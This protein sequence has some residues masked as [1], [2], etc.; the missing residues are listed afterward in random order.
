MTDNFSDS[1][2]RVIPLDVPQVET[3][4]FDGLLAEVDEL[5]ASRER[6]VRAG[7]A[8][9]RSIERVLHEGVQQELI[10]LAVNLQLAGPLVDSDP[11]AARALLDELRH[12]VQRAL[13]AAA[14]LAE[15]IHPPLLEAGGLG[16]ALR[17]AAVR[18]GA[19]ASVE[20]TA[21]GG[22]PPEVIR[23]V[24]LCCLEAFRSSALTA[25]T[26]RDGRGAL[27]V[28][29]VEGRTAAHEP[30]DWVDRLRDRFE[31]LGGTLTVPA[32]DGAAVV[33]RGSLPVPR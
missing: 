1:R 19:T 22:Y 8:D 23:T 26:V 5:R 33:I 3:N 20:I 29:L 15:R 14:Q 27:I 6:L 12:D 28:E 11:T 17:S 9:R 4:E 18:A 31:A 2:R 25:V 30:P 7:D 21:D 10:A 16:A 24:Y 13:E 32:G